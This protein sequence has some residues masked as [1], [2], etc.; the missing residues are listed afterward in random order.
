MMHTSKP[1]SQN[2]T[3]LPFIQCVC[4]VAVVFL[5]TNGGFWTY[6]NTVFWKVSNLIESL[7]Y[8]AVPVFFM[9]SGA[10]LM[11]FSDK[12]TLREFFARRVKKT[13]LPF[14]FWSLVAVAYKLLGHTIGL[15]D[16]RPFSLITGIVGTRFMEIYWFFH[17]SSACICVCRCFLGLRRRNGR[18]YLP[19]SLLLVLFLILPFHFW[20]YLWDIVAAVRFRLLL[21]VKTCGMR[22]VA[23]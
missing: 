9:I 15:S 16:L 19:I 4:S 2:L 7:L 17:Q 1:Q 5:H 11:D 23:I 21:S 10:T 8:F 14:L 20:A 6:S 22:S 3:Y 13:L 18:L 12:Y